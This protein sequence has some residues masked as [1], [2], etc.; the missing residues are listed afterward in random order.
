M[1]IPT[2]INISNYKNGNA[3]TLYSVCGLLFNESEWFPGELQ[4]KTANFN[5]EY[6]EYVYVTI[7]QNNLTLISWRYSQVNLSHK[8]QYFQ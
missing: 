2:R 6:M 3:T 7:A 5:L 8:I 1:K 4:D